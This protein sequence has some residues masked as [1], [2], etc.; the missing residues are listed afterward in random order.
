MSLV[1]FVFVFVVTVWEG[2]SSYAYGASEGS[3]Y[4][5]RDAGRVILSFVKSKAILKDRVSLGIV[6]LVQV[7]LNALCVLLFNGE[8]LC[9]SI[10]R[11]SPCFYRSVHLYLISVFEKR[12][13]NEPPQSAIISQINKYDL[14]NSYLLDC[15]ICLKI[16]IKIHCALN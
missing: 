2:V 4:R 7:A 9:H 11:H 12:Y 13:K 14:M 10:K 3:R 16:G 15:S 1:V 8:I 6:D 5:T